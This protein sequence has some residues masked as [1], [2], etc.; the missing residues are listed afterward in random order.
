[1]VLREQP[2]EKKQTLHNLGTMKQQWINFHW[3]QWRKCFFTWSW[4]ACDTVQNPGCRS[5]CRGQQV[6]QWQK[7]SPPGWPLGGAGNHPRASRRSR[8]ETRDG[9]A[10]AGGR[11]P[12]IQP[13]YKHKTTRLTKM[14][15]SSTPTSTINALKQQQ[16]ITHI[17][18]VLY[19]SYFFQSHVF[20]WIISCSWANDSLTNQSSFSL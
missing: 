6:P 10:D 3:F 4:Q 14:S 15:R 19:L 2:F 17:S 16:V 5:W 20:I 12:T 9:N 8:N 18:A 1:M 7:A 11:S 13:R